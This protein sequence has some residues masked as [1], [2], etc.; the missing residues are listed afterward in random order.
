VRSVAFPHPSFVLSA[1]RD[2]SVRIW[3]LLSASPP[4][5]DATFVSHGSEFINAVSFVPPSSAYPDGLIVSGGKDAIIEVRQ[6]GKLP[7]DNA[8][9]L[10]LG[11]AGNVCALDTS[12]DG[13]MIVSGSWDTE[14]RVWQVGKWESSTV[15]QGHT[16]SVWAVAVYDKE[17]IL[18][19]EP[20]GKE[21]SVLLCAT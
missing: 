19:G 3:K 10:L 21:A 4:A 12:E 9:A 2:K 11:H 14:A 1:S 17:T 20:S 18:T 7:D 5:Y 13:R 6:P 16:A 8:E 15:L